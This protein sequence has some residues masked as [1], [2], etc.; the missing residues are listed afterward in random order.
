MF[1]VRTLYWKSNPAAKQYISYDTW[2][3]V[4]TLVRSVRSQKCPGKQDQPKRYFLRIVGTAGL[5]LDYKLGVRWHF[6][7]RGPIL[8]PRPVLDSS[9]QTTRG[10]QL[11]FFCKT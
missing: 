8:N 3:L 4:A 5:A 6:C 2:Y 11:D 10:N 7:L 1:R 9:A